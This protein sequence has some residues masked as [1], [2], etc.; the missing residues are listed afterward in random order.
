MEHFPLA[1]SNMG[2]LKM[3]VGDYEGAIQDFTTAI[4][5]DPNLYLAYNNRGYGYYH[6]GE[7]EKAAADF[8]TALEIK[9]DFME[10]KLNSACV[11]TKEGNY[12]EALVLLDEVIAE[13]P[14]TGILYT[15]RGLVRE[16]N[17]DVI[18]AC[19]DWTTALGLG[20]ES[21]EEYL[22]ECN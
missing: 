9:L 19:E 4:E 3:V 6:M 12:S 14:E 17:G 22:K 20:E 5:Q 15:N 16:M 7:M 13:N 8:S 18:G 2:S 21:V 10:P 1:Y 11:L